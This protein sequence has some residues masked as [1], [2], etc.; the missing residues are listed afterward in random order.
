MKPF[1]PPLYIHRKE[2]F[3]PELDTS[4]SASL[5]DVITGGRY[6]AWQELLDY[7]QNLSLTSSSEVMISYSTVILYLPLQCLLFFPPFF[8]T[9]PS[10]L[11]S[12]LQKLHFHFYLDTEACDLQY[13]SL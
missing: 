13:T 10:Q 4:G 2:L 12:L 3:W 9:S 5:Q 11:A 6:L 7:L 1:L 8:P